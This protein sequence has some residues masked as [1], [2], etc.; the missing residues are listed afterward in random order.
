LKVIL[1]ERLPVSGLS[2]RSLFSSCFPRG[3]AL[4]LAN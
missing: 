1:A 4:K 3:R 2:K